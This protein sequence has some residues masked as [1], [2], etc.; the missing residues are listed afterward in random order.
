MKDSE[1]KE[2]RVKLTTDILEVKSD[3]ENKTI[4]LKSNL[5]NKDIINLIKKLTKD[6]Y[7]KDILLIVN[8]SMYTDESLNFVEF[9]KEESISTDE[10]QIEIL[11]TDKKEEP[12]LMDS[13]KQDEYTKKIVVNESKVIVGMFN[14]EINVYDY[15][16]K[17]IKLDKKSKLNIDSNDCF[18]YY[19]LND[20]DIVQNPEKDKNLLAL[21]IR[22]CGIHFLEMSESS[23]VNY[24][25]KIEANYEKL[26]SNFKSKNIFVAGKKNGEID[27]Y[28][29]PSSKNSKKNSYSL[30]PEISMSFSKNPIGSLS[31]ISENLIGVGDIDSIYVI[32]SESKVLTTK[33]NTNHHYCTNI[34]S[35]DEKLISSHDNGSFKIWDYKNSGS[36]VLSN[37]KS[38]QGLISGLLTFDNKPNFITSGYDGLIKFWDLRNVKSEYQKIEIE[39][40][41]K[42]F[43]IASINDSNNSRIAVGVSDNLVHF[44][45]IY[46]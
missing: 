24:S 36:L 32:N 30:S 1:H 12:K 11:I 25:H 38:H 41:P 35:I 10:K 44:Y 37:N 31:W 3:L 20:L 6:K 29:I 22:D 13:K 45:D 17:L 26:S 19:F 9:L 14:C 27:I 46:I 18:D 43:S 28:K 42:I 40:K 2:I 16:S 21:S 15:Q 5:F 39:N 34:R 23:I 33:I 4:V 8:G 7:K